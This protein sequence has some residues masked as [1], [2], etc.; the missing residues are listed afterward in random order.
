MNEIVSPGL[1]MLGK[2]FT[3]VQA[4]KS[5]PPHN[6]KTPN[7]LVLNFMVASISHLLPQPQNI[8]HI[9]NTVI[10]DVTKR[11]FL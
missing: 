10:I 4:D 9:Q 8:P 1:A 2:V 5:K 11:A 6:A 3:L 7:Q